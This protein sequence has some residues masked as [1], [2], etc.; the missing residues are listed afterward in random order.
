LKFVGYDNDLA[1]KFVSKTYWRIIE[2]IIFEIEKI[3][4]GT[5][6]ITMT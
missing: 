3:I 5:K 6:E 4:D 1:E 2:G